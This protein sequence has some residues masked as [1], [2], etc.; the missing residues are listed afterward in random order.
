M[1]KLLSHRDRPT[2]VFCYN[3]MLALGALRAAAGHARVPGDIS[4]VGFDDLFFAPYLSPPL[5][6]VDQPKKTMGRLAM[7][8][9]LKLLAGH[10]A[11]KTIHVKG[12][13]IVRQSTGPP[14]S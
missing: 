12:K 4:L 11:D 2:A 3:D 8:L 7:E 9:V 13:L 10:S 1:K 14:H 5:T 6:T